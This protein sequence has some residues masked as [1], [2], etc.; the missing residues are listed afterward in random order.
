MTD[1]KILSAYTTW[2]LQKDVKK[3]LAQWY[4][5][6]GGIFKSWGIY[7]QAMVK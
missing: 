6:Q 7:Y 1:Y 4:T 5:P 3:L 2:G